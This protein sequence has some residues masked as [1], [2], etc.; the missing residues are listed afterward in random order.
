M[1]KE[2]LNKV[3]EKLIKPKYPWIEEFEWVAWD[4][5][6]SMVNYRLEIKAPSIWKKGIRKKIRYKTEVE[7]DMR[8]LFKMLGPE[9]NEVFRTVSIESQYK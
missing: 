7:E 1:N 6:N 5:M 2:I 4:D 8:S 3:T 9:P